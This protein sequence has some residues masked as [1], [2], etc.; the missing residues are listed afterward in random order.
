MNCACALSSSVQILGPFPASYAR[1]CHEGGG[2]CP[3][4]RVVTG[5]GGV[6]SPSE[7]DSRAPDPAGPGVAWCPRAADP[8]RG[9]ARPASQLHRQS[10]TASAGAAVPRRQMRGPRT[11]LSVLEGFSLQTD[12]CGLSLPSCLRRC[13]STCGDGPCRNPIFHSEGVR[14][15]QPRPAA[16]SEVALGST[17]HVNAG[18]GEARGGARGPPLGTSASPPLTAGDLHPVSMS[19]CTRAED[20]PGARWP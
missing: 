9:G 20:L 13:G 6:P 15:S 14:R 19:T 12:R 5:R 11:I 7:R 16:P 2:W 4:G 8:Q 3:G 10:Q 18:P 17:A 1:G